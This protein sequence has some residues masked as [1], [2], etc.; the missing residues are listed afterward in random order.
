MEKIKTLHLRESSSWSCLIVEIHE[1]SN[2][3]FSIPRSF[4][5]SQMKTISQL[6]IM[7]LLVDLLAAIR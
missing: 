7:C 6:D 4:L 5:L 2:T 3:V 1:D